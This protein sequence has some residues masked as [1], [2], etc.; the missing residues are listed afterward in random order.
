[1]FD[2]IRAGSGVSRKGVRSYKGCKFGF[3]LLLFYSSLRQSISDH[4]LRSCGNVTCSRPQQTATRLRL[5]PGTIRSEALGF[6][7]MPV[8]FVYY[9][10]MYILPRTISAWNSFTGT[11]II[12]IIF[13]N[14][15]PQYFSIFPMWWRMPRATD[16]ICI[17]TLKM[18]K[19][20]ASLLGH[21]LSA[22][23]SCR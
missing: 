1:M 17:Y 18:D 10:Y 11:I 4:Y 23:Q 9:T 19:D 12:I 3:L 8:G 15:L 16:K 22:R 7:T 14:C 13:S 21:W 6:T 5:E 2:V 20:K